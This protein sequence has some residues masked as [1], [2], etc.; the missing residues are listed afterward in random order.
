MSSPAQSPGHFAG[1][2]DAALDVPGWWASRGEILTGGALARP[3]PGLSQALARPFV[4]GPRPSGHSRGLPMTRTIGA[5]ASQPTGGSIRLAAG[6]SLTR[7][8]GSGW[9]GRTT[10]G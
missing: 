4:A 5:S 6:G 7:R 9:A 2:P 3:L 10:R 1:G 8:R